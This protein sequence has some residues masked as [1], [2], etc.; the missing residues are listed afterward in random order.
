MIDK[1]TDAPPIKISEAI[2]RLAE[3]LIKKYPK[4]ER[5]VAIIDMAIFAW[6]ISLTSDTKREE[7]E[8]KLIDQFQTE[9]DATGIATIIEQTDIM[10][11]TKK[12]LYPD[13]EYLI[14]KHNLTVTNDGQLTLDVD[15]V[16]Q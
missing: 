16:K 15:T 13:I 11:E 2:L 4:R 9:L 10:V 6:N 12:R 1:K 3:P 14:I 8:R 7:I 5:I